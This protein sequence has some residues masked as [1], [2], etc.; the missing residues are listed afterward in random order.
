LS[1]RRVPQRAERK[2]N[3]NK[4]CK[5]RGGNVL[6]C[7]DLDKTA[8]F[9]GGLKGRNGSNTAMGWSVFEESRKKSKDEEVGAVNCST[10]GKRQ[11]AD[12]VRGGAAITRLGDVGH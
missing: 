8:Q 2:E 5:K 1:D 10:R 12:N 4:N 6:I 11:R 3:W 9:W 7:R